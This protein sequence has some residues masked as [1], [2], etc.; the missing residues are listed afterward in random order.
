MTTERDYVLAR[1][2]RPKNFSTL[3]GQ[4]ETKQAL[5]NAL[6]TG[7]LHHAYLFSG[8]RGIGKTTIARILAKCFN[9]E[10]GVSATPC[11][12][13]D[14]CRSIDAG[15]CVDLIEID[16]ASRTKVEETRQLLDNVPYAPTIARY[17]I[18]LFDEVHMFS[19]NSFNALL[20]TLEEPPAHVK[21]M[22]ATTAPQQLPLTILSRCLQFHLKHID[23]EVIASHLAHILEQEKIKYEHGALQLLSRMAQGSMRDALSLTDQAA[24]YCADDIRETSVR[25]MLHTVDTTLVVEL[26]EALAEGDA[27]KIVQLIAQSAE[28]TPHYPEM[29]GELLEQLH[30]I[31]LCHFLPAPPYGV[32]EDIIALAKKIT[33]EEAHMF[34]KKGEEGLRNLAWAPD[35]RTGVE[36][37]LLSMVVGQSSSAPEA[38]N[39]S[40]TVQKKDTQ[41]KDKSKDA[42]VEPHTDAS[43]S[44]LRSPSA[45]SVLPEKKPFPRAEL[46]NIK[47]N[48]QRYAQQ[49]NALSEAFATTKETDTIRRHLSGD[50]DATSIRKVP[51][52]D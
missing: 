47:H 16:A 14:C 11:D 25:A 43:Q 10:R 30:N 21:F 22:L 52:A 24:A 15:T 51:P 5:I 45:A 18:Y 3:V 44:R 1:Q 48:I 38:Q 7:R 2:W 8:T 13:C 26:L 17:K 37:T 34:Y 4:E 46:S 9:C 31:V 33:R 41:P 50:V 27:S 49:S 19:K 42:H 29:L 28:Q 40:K 36:M 12:E 35:E 32:E 39:V 23:K 20:K 6:T